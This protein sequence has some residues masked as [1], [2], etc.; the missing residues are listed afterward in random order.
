MLSKSSH[1]T[2]KMLGRLFA[3]AVT[4]VIAAATMIR[5]A[6]IL[7][8]AGDITTTACILHSNALLRSRYK[9]YYWV[10]VAMYFLHINLT[11]SRLP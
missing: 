4:V 2:S 7:S 9:H 1:M 10:T 6:I 11:P 8:A 5:N 3:D